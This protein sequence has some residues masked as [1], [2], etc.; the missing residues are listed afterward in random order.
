M[1]RR[2]L[3]AVLAALI[4]VLATVAVAFGAGAAHYG[5]VSPLAGFRLF[6]LGATVGMLLALLLG[7]LGLIRTRAGSGRS[8][9]GSAWLGTAL[10]LALFLILA[11]SA[12]PGL[13]AP[14]IHD[15][16]T[17]IEDPPRFSDAVRDAEGRRNGIEYPDGGPQVPELQRE[18]YPDLQPIR[19]EVPPEEAFS[20]AEQAAR[21]L[22]W[23]VTRRAPERG[24]LE[25]Y[26]V[27][28]VFR[29]ADDIAVRV[30]PRDPGSVV[31]VR[32]SSRVG[33]G[34]LGANAARIRAFRREIRDRG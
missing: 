11:L 15:I 25:A 3:T 14:A 30:R 17:N 13:R 16:T 23:T 26:D 22:G 12:G 18:A 1:E 10:G 29:F 33:R 2:S 19:L 21:E 27:S 8:G 24:T 4:G 31:D 20:R 6:S 7:I 34:D 9:R 32:S 5:L 28:A